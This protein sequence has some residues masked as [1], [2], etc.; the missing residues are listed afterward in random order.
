MK[1][2]AAVIMIGNAHLDP[3][4]LWTRL[5]GFAE[6]V[7][8]IKSAVMRAEEED[9]FVFTCS[10][11]SYYEFVKNHDI[12]LFSK[13][14]ELVK[15][16]KWNIVGG[17]WVQPDNNL[18]GG[19]VYARHALYSQNFYKREFGI[20][21]KTGYCVDSFGHNGN[22]P[23]ILIK[24][25]MENYVFMRPGKWENDKIPHLFKWVGIDGS[26]VITYKLLQEAYNN[27]N[28]ADRMEKDISECL[29]FANEYGHN[30]MCF[31]G[32]GNHGGGPTRESIKRINKLIDD[33]MN[34]RYGGADYFFGTIKDKKDVLPAY[35]G[36]LQHHAI[37]C[38]SVAGRIKSLQ[39]KAEREL[40]KAEKLMYLANILTGAEYRGEEIERAYK[41]V[42]FNTFH[43]IICGC[44][45]KEGLDA[46]ESGYHESISIAQR[47]K[48]KAIID[49]TK[50]IN[51]MIDGVTFKGKEDWHI[52]EEDD[53]GFPVMVFNAEGH[54]VEKTVKVSRRYGRC[55]DAEGNPVEVQYV[56]D[57]YINGE[58]RQAT[59]FE[60]TVPPL[61]YAVYWLYKNKT[62]QPAEKK[63]IA[64]EYCLENEFIKVR[65]DK[66]SGGIASVFDKTSGREHIASPSFIPCVM[67]DNNDT[68]AHGINEYDYSALAPLKVKD[69]FVSEN[70]NITG[71]VT[72]LY[73][74]GNTVM[75][76][77]FSLY[78]DDKNIYVSFKAL[79]NEKS[80]ICALQA[81]TG[82]QNPVLAYQIP[83]GTMEKECD[84]KEQASL[85][86][87]VIKDG[88]SAFGVVTDGRPSVSAKGPTLR[89]IAI[90]NSVYANHYGDVSKGEYDYT[91]EGL[92]AFDYIITCQKDY[93]TLTK[94]SNTFDCPDY[95]ID[96]YHEGKLPQRQ[97]NIKIDAEN[98]IL[99]SVKKAENGGGG[100][101]RLYESAGKETDAAIM[102]CGV[103]INCRFKPYEVK[104]FIING[105]EVKES[106][107]PEE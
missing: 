16:G 40:L 77:R 54:E 48:E 18:I 55:A 47:I 33:G 13:I 90:R 69:I 21:C 32:V 4:W 25:G 41:N 92:T 67:P 27:F 44:C 14:K 52:W 88:K 11:A 93:S 6:V 51:T 45:I 53:L 102:L 57:R 17:Y 71:A 94:L 36:D 101:I 56:S 9:R 80:S 20:T 66:S 72:V 84:G 7:S 31:Y 23:Q 50:N 95:V 78:R 75:T 105:K 103:N 1:E 98:I 43:D 49:I 35:K 19:E 26:S 96:S 30:M 29:D 85:G 38:Y 106:N 64:G 24:S 5:E 62:S 89:F 46:A 15:K 100:V 22:L 3:V 91:D 65:F 97:G 2:D 87:A 86:F 81:H 58:E 74:K 37:G 82:A 61:G 99:T 8:T 83:F 60:A 10:S 76:Q 68:W 12:K 42:L 34:I 70:G 39:R 107:F 73:E 59:L 79:Y 104:T 28:S 63:Y